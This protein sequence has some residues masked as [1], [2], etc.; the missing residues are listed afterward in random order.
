MKENKKLIWILG[1]LVLAVWGMIARQILNAVTTEDSDDASS[2]RVESSSYTSIERFVYSDE[3]RDPFHYITPHVVLRKDTARKNGQKQ[4]P[5]WT[6]PPLKLS[7]ILLDKKK[8]TA[9]LEGNDGT[10]LFVH[11][12]DTLNGIRL[13]A[14]RQSSVTYLYRRKQKK[15]KLQ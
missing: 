3:A 12:G 1:V 6:P 2:P 5:V 8:R 14:I 11:E 4:F 10:I 9:M 7:G 15:L 13:V